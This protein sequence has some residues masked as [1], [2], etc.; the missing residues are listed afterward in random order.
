MRH[1]F[2]TTCILIAGAAAHADPQDT[3]LADQPFTSTPWANGD[4]Y[5]VTLTLDAC[6]L[7]KTVTE[8]DKSD[9][10][11]DSM[12]IDVD[13]AL[14]DLDR[15]EVVADAVTLWAVEGTEVQCTD[16]VGEDCVIAGRPGEQISVPPSVSADDYLDAF[17]TKIAMCQG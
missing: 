1:F 16:I 5:T 9:T 8:F 15:L 12:R 6:L 4:Y 14:V 17:R 2:A 3:I 10:S 11:E 13:L 7:S